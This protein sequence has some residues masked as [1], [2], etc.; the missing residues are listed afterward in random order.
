MPT[1]NQLGKPSLTIKGFQLWVHDRQFPN[2]SD[3]W[4]GNWLLA[5]AHCRG[6]ITD[7]WIIS[8]PFIHLSELARFKD[9]LE[10]FIEGTTDKAV[11]STLEQLLFI[12]FEGKS[13]EILMKVDIAPNHIDKKHEY[14][15]IVSKNDIDRLNPEL[16]E[17]LNQYP[18]KGISK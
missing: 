8:A 2:R 18:I 6:S 13:D 16:N 9:E 3:Y 7:V 11:L 4:D 15:F 5:T 1:A 14:L 17:L 10:E 12:E